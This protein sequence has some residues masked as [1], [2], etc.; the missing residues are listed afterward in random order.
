MA[1]FPNTITLSVVVP[2]YRGEAFLAELVDHLQTLKSRWE[3]AAISLHFTEAVFVLDAPA[4]QSN[5][6]ISELSGNHDWIRVV[7]L[8]RNYG[9]H[10]AT[11]AGILY[12]S[13]DWVV[14][15]DE[16]LQHHPAHIETLL[17]T[18]V[19]QNAD[20]VYAQPLE[21]THGGGYRDGFS[22]RIKA[23]IAGLSGNRFVRSFNSFRLIRGDIARAASSI[24]AQ[25][26]YFDVALTWFTHR[27]SS[28][29]IPMSDD[30]YTQANESG[31]GFWSLVAH[32]KRLILT[33]NLRALRFTITLSG[34]AF[35]SS[36]AYGVWILY[37]KYF[38]T[39]P[40][41]VEGWT[42][43]MMVILGF[44]G[45]TIFILGIIVEFLHMSMLQLQGKPAFFVT[46]RSSDALL[47]SELEKLESQCKS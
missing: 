11:V 8:S 12:T 18:A 13:G 39:I 36:A 19:R 15:L 33:S 30:R 20:V 9:Q 26:T 25:F 3:S 40:I 45:I 1:D 24:C 35:L 43:L 23:L 44:G 42:S 2:V 10:S 7:E 22:S 16:D 46:D 34:L 31:Y 38:S 41:E 28:T 5:Q 37:V 17:Q 14:T 47:I 6:I 27:I 32:A 4:D 21:S 29:G